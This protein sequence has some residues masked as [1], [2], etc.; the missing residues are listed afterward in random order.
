[1]GFLSN[2]ALP[3]L[4]WELKAEY[5]LYLASLAERRPERSGALVV[6]AGT[7]PE[8]LASYRCWPTRSLLSQRVNLHAMCGDPEVARYL[9]TRLSREQSWRHLAFL[10]GHWKL[11]GYGIWAV[12]ERENGVFVGRIGFADPDGWPVASWSGP[13][14]GIGGG[15]ATP[16]KAPGPPWPTS[17]PRWTRTV[18]SASLVARRTAPPFAWPNASARVCKAAPRFWGKSTSSTALI[19]KA[20]PGLDGLIRA[21]RQRKRLVVLTREAKTSSS[22]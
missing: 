14:C 6:V 22:T 4:G 1:M 13:C 11:R 19:G 2:A 20:A 5:G 3:L 17:S 15:A 7:S 21:R 18:S 12:E 8:W 16:Q 9:L 10:V